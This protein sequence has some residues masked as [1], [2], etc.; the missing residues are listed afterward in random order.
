MRPAASTAQAGRRNPRPGMRRSSR[1]RHGFGRERPTARPPFPNAE[2]SCQ[3]RSP[4]A[5]G[6][7]RHPHPGEATK[8]RPAAPS[9]PSDTRTGHRAPRLLPGHRQASD[10]ALRR[11]RALRRRPDLQSFRP[12][13]RGNARRDV[14]VRPGPLR[15][16]RSAPGAISA[17]GPDPGLRSAVRRPRDPKRRPASRATPQRGPRPGARAPP[18]PRRRAALP[19]RPE[20]GRLRAS[21]SNPHREGPAPQEADR[22]DRPPG[23][24]IRQLRRFAPQQRLYLRAESHG[25]VALRPTLRPNPGASSLPSRASCSTQPPASSLGTALSVARPCAVR[26]PDIERQEAVEQDALAPRHVQRLLQSPVLE[27]PEPAQRPENPPH[28]HRGRRPPARLRNR[29]VGDRAQRGERRRILP[30]LRH[31][32]Q[33]PEDDADLTLRPPP[34]QSAGMRALRLLVAN[35]P[36]PAMRTASSFAS[37]SAI[38]SSTVSTAPSAA[39][40][41]SLIRSATRPIMSDLFIHPHPAAVACGQSPEP[42]PAQSTARPC[43]E[44]QRYPGRSFADTATARQFQTTAA[45]IPVERH[46]AYKHHAALPSPIPGHAISA[47]AS[48]S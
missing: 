26:E 18:Y 2:A 21:S 16:R 38:A 48:A 9:A 42:A 29:V 25:Q 30:I 24:R 10:R 6:R 39:D 33:P 5:T 43:L 28:G 13:L 17:G 3:G 37:A 35:V 19:D 11:S 41:L 34:R 45:D 40:L 12:P 15:L 47:T 1:R 32:R 14:R 44:P 36:N 8:A 46:M 31:C 27:Q 4:A 7:P 20:S 22:R 23:A